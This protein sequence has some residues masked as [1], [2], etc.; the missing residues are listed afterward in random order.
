MALRVDARDV[1]DANARTRCA[2]AGRVV[3][4]FRRGGPNA[5]DDYVYEAE[6]G[7]A[8]DV[9]PGVPIQLEPHGAE[10]RLRRRGQV[11]RVAW[12]PPPE[13][14][15][16]VGRD[17]RAL[18]RRFLAACVEGFAEQAGQGAAAMIVRKLKG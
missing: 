10:F 8:L 11:L 15:A 7:P 5:W 4:R 17:A 12:Q 6:D 9:L 2:F 16:E 3:G 1:L 14:L 18:R 13:V